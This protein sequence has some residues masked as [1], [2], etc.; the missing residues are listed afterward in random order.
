M[1][2][3][4]TSKPTIYRIQARIDSELVVIPTK[5]RSFQ[6][7]KDMVCNKYNLKPSAILGDCE[8]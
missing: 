5:A 4:N 3:S 2:H 8:V 1:I 6:Q 7:A